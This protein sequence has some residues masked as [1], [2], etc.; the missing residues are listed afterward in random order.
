MNELVRNLKGKLN[1]L[2]DLIADDFDA[3][4]ERIGLSLKARNIENQL[5]NM[6]SFMMDVE[7]Q[8]EQL[9]S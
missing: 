5:Q 9:Q 8:I 1:D 3:N 6:M 2:E 4:Q 7:E